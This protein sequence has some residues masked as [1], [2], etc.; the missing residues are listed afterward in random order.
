MRAVRLITFESPE[1]LGDKN[2]LTPAEAIKLA[3]FFFDIHDHLAMRPQAPAYWHRW[4]RG[5]DMGT[6]LQ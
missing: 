6:W 4:K 2:R 1:P 3:A 5:N